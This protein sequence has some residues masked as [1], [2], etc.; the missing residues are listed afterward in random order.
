MSLGTRA[1]LAGVCACNKAVAVILN[2]RE[3]ALKY[4]SIMSDPP[5]HVSPS[6]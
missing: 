5:P 3:A 4:G 1:A 2:Q 6:G